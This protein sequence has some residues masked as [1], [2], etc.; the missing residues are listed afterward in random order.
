MIETFTSAV[1][2]SR[3]RQ[4]LAALLFAASAVAASAGLGALLGLA[5]E[6]LGA[7]RAVFAAAGLALLGAAREA[8]LLRL[9]LPQARRQVPER[10]RS[11]LP[12]PVWATGYGA[13]LGAGIFTYQP[14]AT[15]WV[16][17]AAAL[18]LA[19]P[20][21]AG[22]CFSLYGAGRALTLFWPPRR[23]G[24]TEVVERLA[25]RRRLLL[26]ANVVGLVGCGILL[27]AAPAAQGAYVGAGLDPA[28][29]AGALARG[30]QDG[31]V[32]VQPTQGAVV[33]YGGAAEPA[34]DGALLAYADSGGIRV[35]RWQS[36]DE[37]ARINGAVSLPA[38]DWPLVAYVQEDG[39]AH[40]L[41]LRNLDT[42]AVRLIVS[43]AAGTDLGRPS[44]RGGKLA[45]HANRRNLSRIMLQTLATG[46]RRDVARSKIRLLA[47]P[48]LRASRILW[49]EQWSGGAD[50]RI[51][52]TSGG[53]RRVLARIRSRDVGYWTTALGRNAAYV[54]KWSLRTGAA[55]VHKLPL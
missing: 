53:K 16:A 45:W 36:R 1:C 9:P 38:L 7:R 39:S 49:T 44:L 46:R 26:R 10:W 8:G 18:A 5:G 13:G 2:G 51:A 29:T 31:S 25:G 42:G 34:L 23:R 50:V 52:P 21:A 37:V 24:A 55:S 6:G 35:V 30:L 17:C 28:E 22:L 48:S 27:A 19:R 33:P 43:V 15:F 32:V 20:L 41:V 40:S 14:V 54:T 3:N 47:N 12:L 11:E 4:R